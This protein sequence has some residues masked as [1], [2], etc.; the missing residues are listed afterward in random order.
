MELAWLVPALPLA[1][2]AV[3]GLLTLRYANLSSFINILAIGGSCAIAWMLFFRVLGGEPPFEHVVSVVIV[4]TAH[5]T[6]I[7]PLVT[8][9]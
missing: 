8:L 4:N 6:Q 7:V 5:I 2:F 3:I 9:A 1:A